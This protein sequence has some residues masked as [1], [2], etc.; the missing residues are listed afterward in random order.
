MLHP[1]KVNA[2]LRAIHLLAVQARFMAQNEEPYGSIARLLDYVEMLPRLVASR[3]D[4]TETFRA[5]LQEAARLHPT[6]A[7]ALLRFDEAA[8]DSDW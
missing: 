4:E 5:Y 8:E 7:L 2:A 1:G 3:Q 6:C